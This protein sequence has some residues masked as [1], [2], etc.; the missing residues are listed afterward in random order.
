MSSTLKTL[1]GTDPIYSTNLYGQ[2]TYLTDTDRLNLIRNECL[3]TMNRRQMSSTLKE[4]LG[5]DPIYSRKLYG[6]TTYLTDESRLNLIRN[7][8]E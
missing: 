2:T 3:K 5:T 8:F 7:Y 1:L 4:L 6:Q